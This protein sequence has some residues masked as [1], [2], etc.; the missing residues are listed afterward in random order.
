[1]DY[2]LGFYGERYV[3]QFLYPLMR[4]GYYVYHDFE[5][6]A[7][8]KPVN[9]DHILV[10]PA[11]VFVVETKTRRKRKGRPGYKEH[12]VKYNGKYFD[13]PWGTDSYGINQA[14]ANAK[15]LKRLLEGATQLKSIPVYSVLT[16]PGWMISQKE[17]FKNPAVVS[18]K[19]IQRYISRQ[20][21]H[22][23]MDT[24]V[25][26]QLAFVIEERNKIKG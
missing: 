18:P 25:I 6:Q 14:Q 8:G 19:S 3:A 13:F 7:Q 24:P 16:L 12:E 20:P 2:N 23:A 17:D 26:G 1:M 4:E 5:I 11:G 15:S 22:P 9:I 21:N 10:G